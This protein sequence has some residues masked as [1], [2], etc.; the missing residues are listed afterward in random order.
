MSDTIK[1][2]KAA[3][4]ADINAS[5]NTMT[6]AQRHE[7]SVHACAKLT[8]LEAFTNASVVMLYL[9][10]AN[11]ID[12]TPIALRCF[13][14][15]KAV[16][17][18]KV[19]WARREMEA[20]EVTSIDDHVLDCDERGV[21]TP[22]NFRPISPRLI[23]MVIVP[24]RAYDLKGNRLGRGVGYYDRF[25]TRLKRSATTVGLVFDQQIVDAV[26]VEPH[27]V[28]VDMVVT[29]RRVSRPKAAKP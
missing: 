2:S 24:A 9:P 14:Q 18:P 11:E 6:E 28:A 4:R 12:V 1:N 21:R 15:G 26:P 19:D 3:I 5:L 13:S 23:D 20:V 25:L 22:R 10:M 7:A 17:V 16:C 8:G 29:D 27:D